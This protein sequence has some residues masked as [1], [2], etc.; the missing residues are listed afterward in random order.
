MARFKEGADYKITVRTRGEDGAITSFNFSAL[1]LPGKAD[2]KDLVGIVSQKYGKVSKGNL[3]THP[4]V[5]IISK[6]SIKRGERS[7]GAR[8]GGR[9][10]AFAENLSRGGLPAHPAPPSPGLPARGDE[11]AAQIV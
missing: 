11:G 4:R 1:K 8:G 6:R 5:S 2:P 7:F 3:W 9:G 10:C